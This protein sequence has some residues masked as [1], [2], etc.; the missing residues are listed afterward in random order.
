[1]RSSAEIQNDLDNLNFLTATLESVLP[2][3]QIYL[4][5]HDKADW[6]IFIDQYNSVVEEARRKVGETEIELKV[7]QFEEELHGY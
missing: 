2:M 6:S 4:K 7:K 3:V 1:M 5:T